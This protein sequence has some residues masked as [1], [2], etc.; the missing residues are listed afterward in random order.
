M[1]AS[2]AAFQLPRGP[3]WAAG[4]PGRAVGR[5]RQFPESGRTT[6]PERRGMLPELRSRNANTRGLVTMDSS[7]R[8]S[9]A[10]PAYFRQY[11]RSPRCPVPSHPRNRRAFRAAPHGRVAHVAGE[12]VGV[13]VSR[14][15][16]GSSSATRV[17][18][19]RQAPTKSRR[20]LRS[21]A[22]IR[23]PAYRRSDSR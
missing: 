23:A 8:A 1:L 6:K 9:G 4:A 21:V 15:K 13:R 19:S 22:S 10:E 20:I 12:H 5:D 18:E 7:G 14:V 2:Q 11:C 3:D 17:A 16:C